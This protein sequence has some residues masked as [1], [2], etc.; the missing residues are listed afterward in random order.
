MKK[1]TKNYLFG[2]YG[3]FKPCKV[4]KRPPD[5]T[6]KSG[7]M[8]WHGTNSKGQYM[9]R[10]S[11]HWSRIFYRRK[12]SSFPIKTIKKV[13]KS[14]WLLKSGDCGKIHTHNLKTIF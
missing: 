7:S 4:P 12:Y 14:I 13:S 2:T 6:S 1:I 3:V 11:D 9:I 8:Y 5:F 10:F